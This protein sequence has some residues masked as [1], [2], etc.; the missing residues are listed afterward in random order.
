MMNF[1][2][3]FNNLKSS[4]DANVK[5]FDGT[6]NVKWVFAGGAC[7]SAEYLKEN[8]GIDKLDVTLK[9]GAIITDTADYGMSLNN[10]RLVFGTKDQLQK[11]IC[12]VKVSHRRKR[13]RS[14][15]RLISLL[16]KTARLKIIS[17]PHAV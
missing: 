16:A 12:S 3:K 7:Q 2:L 4:Y 9:D 17:K 1:L 14:S 13:E 11:M 5:E 10:G 6:W 8:F 15:L